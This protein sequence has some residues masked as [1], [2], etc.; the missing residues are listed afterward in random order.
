MESLTSS[1]ASSLEIKM[2]GGASPGV[3][4]TVAL[5]AEE[6]GAAGM[7]RTAE[8]MVKAVVTA[9]EKETILII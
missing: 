3:P 1:R 7:A 8:A 9:I 4:V 5:G 6:L 2:A